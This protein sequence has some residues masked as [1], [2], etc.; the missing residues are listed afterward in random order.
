MNTHTINERHLNTRSALCCFTINPES[1]AGFWRALLVVVVLCL[2]V[3]SGETLTHAHSFNFAKSCC[4]EFSPDSAK[5]AAILASTKATDVPASGCTV[6]IQRLQ[7]STSKSGLVAGRV[8]RV[9]VGTFPICRLLPLPTGRPIVPGHVF[10]PHSAAVG[11]SPTLFQ[12]GVL[13]TT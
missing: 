9:C 4:V 12:L 5:S 3:Q 13:L 8:H 7:I 2:N 11:G 1:A 6:E 10:G